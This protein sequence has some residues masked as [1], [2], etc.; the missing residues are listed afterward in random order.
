MKSFMKRNQGKAALLLC[1]F[2]AVVLAIALASHRHYPVLAIAGED[3]VGTWMSGVLLVVCA[4]IS[5]SIGIRQDKVLWLL[6]ALFFFLLACD[7]RFM[8]HEQLKEKI[9]FHFGSTIGLSRWVAE[10]PVLVGAAFGVFVTYLLWQFLNV[11][12]RILLL[13]AALLGGASVIIDVMSSGV[14][15]E[16]CFKLT[17]ELAM[18]CSLLF[19]LD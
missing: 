10:L 4:S 13:L 18:A 14:F 2:F 11:K 8:F 19:K 17:G 6:L 12:S 9:I 16:E 5:I 1:G 7:E 3:S 15:W